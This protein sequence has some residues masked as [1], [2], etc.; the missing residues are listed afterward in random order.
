MTWLIG[1]L[2]LLKTCAEPVDCSREDA[3]GVRVMDVGL[4]AAASFLMEARRGGSAI[5]IRS[6]SSSLLESCRPDP[7]F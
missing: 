7:L 3:G 6:S 2:E 1:L 4:K 5:S